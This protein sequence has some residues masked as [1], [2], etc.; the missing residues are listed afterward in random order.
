MRNYLI[1]FF[2]DFEYNIED[3][4]VLLNTY[5]NIIDCAPAN[6]LLCDVLI[7]YNADMNLNCHEQI[8]TRARNIAKIINAHPYTTE[9][10]VFICMTKHLK[11]LYVEHNIDL[12]IYH[13]SVLD[14]K[15]KIQECRVVRG[16]CGSF[17]GNWF[18]EF[19]NLQRFALGRLQFEIIDSP[20]DYDKNGI[21]LNK[22]QTK[23]IN[24]HIPRTLTPIDKDSCDKSYE[25]AKAFFRELF[26]GKTVFVCSSWLLYP[27]NL[28]IFPDYTNTHRFI[29]EY[30]IVYSNENNGED[31]WRLFDTD[32]KHPDR[33]PQNGT[34]RRCYVEHLKKGGRV[35]WGLGV[36]IL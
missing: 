1:E 20:I 12:Q 35:G 11:D 30:D 2:K 16:I 6:E 4:Q 7:D 10:L 25:Q 36:K 27:I 19:F 3:A 17:V 28:D 22:G 24:V 14:L 31:L 26:T 23:V 21:I 32:E 15:W 13:D 33:L 29:S 8:L 5:D 9:L 18:Y 34:L